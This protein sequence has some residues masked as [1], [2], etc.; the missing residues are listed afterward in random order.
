MSQRTRVI[1]ILLWIYPAIWRLEYGGELT[2]TLACRPLTLSIVFDVVRSGILQRV[3]CAEAWHIGGVVMAFW[4]IIG[5]GVNSIAPLSPRAYNYF[6]QLNWYIEL[7]VGYVSVAWHAK[8]LSAAA[9]AAGKAALIGFLPE[10][11]LVALWAAGLVHPTILDM[12][13][14]PHLIGQGITDL[15]I[16]S[17]AAVSSFHE[18]IGIPLTL[19]PALVV[20]FVGGVIA[21]TVSAIRARFHKA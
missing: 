19:L 16:R 17:E 13:G 18:L 3:R 15:C 5:T 1:R 8:N 2:H 10:C 6:F 20:G 4:L 21:R 7:A 14:A 12:R 11:F 9:W